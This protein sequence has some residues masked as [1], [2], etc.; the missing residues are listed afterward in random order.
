MS[1]FS[2]NF[3]QAILEYVQEWE[4]EVDTV[5]GFYEHTTPATGTF[6][7]S[8]QV[9]VKCLRGDEPWNHHFLGDLS[10]FLSAVL[11]GVE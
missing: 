2:D 9:I 7:A 6:D 8:T 3:K 11:V 1:D 5:V 10:Q 4:P